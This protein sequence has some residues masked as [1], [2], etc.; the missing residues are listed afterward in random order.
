MKTIITVSPA[1]GAGQRTIRVRFED[2]TFGDR[3]VT[4]EGEIDPACMHGRRFDTV[5][6][7]RDGLVSMLVLQ[8]AKSH[9]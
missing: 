5:P 8:W 6:P 7:S 1:N 2:D 3:V 9:S 4:Q